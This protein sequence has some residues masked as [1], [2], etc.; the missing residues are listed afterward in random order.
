[1]AIG[2]SDIGDSGTNIGMVSHGCQKSMWLSKGL[3]IK[4]ANGLLSGALPITGRRVTPLPARS[5]YR[6]GV[7]ALHNSKYRVMIRHVQW[8]FCNRES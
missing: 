3:S 8:F 5:R 2:E 1:M 6:D 4:F 7:R